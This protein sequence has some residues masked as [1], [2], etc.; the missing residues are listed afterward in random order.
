MSKGTLIPL[1][2]PAV[3]ALGA[4]IALTEARQS[5]WAAVG[6]RVAVVVTVSAACALLV[7]GP[8]VKR[9][10]DLFGS[11]TG[12]AT[13]VTI[14]SAV[15]ERASAANV[16]RSIAANFR[17]GD[18]GAGPDSVT[19][20]I[21][22][23]ALSP[24]H[25]WTGAPIGDPDFTI[26]GPVDVFEHGDFSQLERNEDY[27]ANPWHVLLIA[28]AL[29][30]LM[31]RWARGDQ[32]AGVPV[33]IGVAL[34]VG[35][36]LFASTTKWSLYAT[37]Y[38]LPVLILWAPLI[39]IALA[40]LHHVVLRVVAVLLVVACLPVLFDSSTRPLLDRP[41][42]H[43]ATSPTTSRRGPTAISSRSPTRTSSGCA[44]PSSR[45]GARASEWPTH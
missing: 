22:L 42:A 41:D 7:A 6:R 3:L 8:F 16:V 5:S 34:A 31:I 15:S 25:E 43:A 20:R 17:I 29:V 10:H 11:F 44:T 30:A 14:N 36:V 24:V 26:G 18:G 4:R 33:L 28:F 35:F 39:A 38:Q 27:G 37:R 12:P 23:D 45:V 21:V 13:R 40:G 1:V 2:A 32:R 19:S 9:N